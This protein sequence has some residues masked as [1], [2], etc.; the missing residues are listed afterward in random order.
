[1]SKSL[2][3]SPE[4]NTWLP[5]KHVLGQIKK[6]V[7]RVTG[8]YLNLL[9]KSR[10]FYRF[11]GKNIILCFLKGKMP[12][13]MHKIIFFSRKKYVWL[14]YLKFSD[15]LPETHCDLLFYLALEAFSIIYVIISAIL[16]QMTCCTQMQILK[17]AWTKLKP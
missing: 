3:I 13:K 17:V 7:F 8:P 12:F 11:S 6:P 4:N 9:M 5:H 15:P 14:P 2:N 16:E 10:I 1:M